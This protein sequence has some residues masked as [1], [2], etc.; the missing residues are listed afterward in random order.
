MRVVKN[1]NKSPPTRIETQNTEKQ[2]FFTHIEAQNIGNQNTT[3]LEQIKTNVNARRWNQSRINK[4][5]HDRKKDYIT[6]H[7]NEDRKK[8]KNH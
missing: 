5:I 4:E 7:K 6:I 3:Y 8:Q 2:G 1:M